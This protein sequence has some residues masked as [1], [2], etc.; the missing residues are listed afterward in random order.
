VQFIRTAANGRIVPCNPNKILV[1]TTQT[2]RP[3]KRILPIGFQ[4][5][6][7][8]G[9]SGIGK[10]IEALDEKVA[11]L[12][13]FNSAAPKLVPLATA[14]ALLDDIEPTLHF[15]EDDAPPFSWDA[16]KAALTHLSHQHADPA[17][18]GK[19]LVW[20]AEGRDSARMASA[21]SHATYIETPD[22]EKTEGQLAKTYAIDHPI[23]FLLRQDGTAQKGWRDTPFYWPVIRA[24]ANTPTAIYT[25]ETID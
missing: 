22:S 5:G 24:Q 6:Y 8:T 1:A 3:H 12:C 2:I 18:R 20:A 25:A 11:D 14:I 23:L 10:M 9:A 21:S 19:V 7:K 15:P 13:G 16:A 17:Q 4:S